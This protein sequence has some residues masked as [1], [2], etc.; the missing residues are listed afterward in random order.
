[1]LYKSII[2]K[3]KIILFIENNFI[4]KKFFLYNNI[5]KYKKYIKKYN[6]LY[7]EFYIINNNYY[8]IYINLIKNL[9][10]KFILKI[11]LNKIKK[12]KIITYLNKNNNKKKKNKKYYLFFYNHNNNK[13]IKNIIYLN[14]K[15][16]YK[17]KKYIFFYFIK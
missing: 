15:L 13:L 17:I 5:S 4:K 6:I 14:K 3:N 10:K 8:I 12:K 9:F 16:F 11:N 1:M 2:K 7:I